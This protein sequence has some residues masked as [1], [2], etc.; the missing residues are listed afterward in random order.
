[1]C[2]FPGPWVGGGACLDVW[3]CEPLLARVTEGR[4]WEACQLF[5][6]AL[7]KQLRRTGGASNMPV[8]S[9]SSLTLWLGQASWPREGSPPPPA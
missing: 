4:D 5:Q 2:G 8:R 1:M 3:V 6:P 9:C 7:G